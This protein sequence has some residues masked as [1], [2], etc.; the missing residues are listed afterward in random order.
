[1]DTALEKEMNKKMISVIVPVHNTFRYV[2]ECLESI[3]NQTYANIEVICIDSSTDR[4]V[5]ILKDMAG[6]D[7]RIRLIFDTIIWNAKCFND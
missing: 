7:S 3:L 6:E 1:M 5:E 4:T 2:K